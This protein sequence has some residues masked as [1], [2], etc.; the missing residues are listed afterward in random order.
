M[1][2]V[3]SHVCLR[4]QSWAPWLWQLF[5]AVRWSSHLGCCLGQLVGIVGQKWLRRTTGAV[6]NARVALFH[7]P[8]TTFH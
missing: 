8:Q 1:A 7:V 6:P 2:A 5:I 4:H 3:L